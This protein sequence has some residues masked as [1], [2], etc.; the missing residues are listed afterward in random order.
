M[1]E[2]ILCQIP[3][4]RCKRSSHFFNHVLQRSD[5][6]FYPFYAFLVRHEGFNSPLHI[7]VVNHKEPSI[8]IRSLIGKGWP[9]LDIRIDIQYDAVNRGQYIR[10]VVIS[11]ETPTGLAAAQ[12]LSHKRQLKGIGSTEDGVRRRAER[13]G[14]HLQWVG[15]LDM[16]DFEAFLLHEFRKILADDVSFLERSLVIAD[17]EPEEWARDV[18]GH[19]ESV[20]EVLTSR[21]IVTPIDLFDGADRTA[22][23][24]RA[25]RL[26]GRFGELMVYWPDMLEASRRL[27]DEGRDGILR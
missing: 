21:R 12:L 5:F 11:V 24:A 7:P 16:G 22:A 23:L 4:I 19:I 13:L 8:F 20:L 27:R 3:P 25:Q 2:D 17:D 15:A 18:R 1:A 10:H 26:I 9:L 6:S 14:R